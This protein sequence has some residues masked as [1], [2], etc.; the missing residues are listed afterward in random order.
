[1]VMVKFL[2]NKDS[3]T[4]A[5]QNCRRKRRRCD[6]SIPICAKCAVAGEECMGYGMRLVWTN[7][8]A[9]RGKLMGKTFEN[10]RDSRALRS[11]YADRA[12]IR[13]L[14]T[15]WCW[16][17]SDATFSTLDEISRFYL[18]YCKSY[19]SIARVS[20]GLR[21]DKMTLK[22]APILFSRISSN[23][24]HFAIF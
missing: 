23:G 7:S 2:R 11:C 17:A 8:V 20:V 6:L 10:D 18:S 4:K 1:M 16:Q 24:I 5:C 22:Y 19:K 13:P 15:A 9:S 3:Q 14:V 12:V 21:A